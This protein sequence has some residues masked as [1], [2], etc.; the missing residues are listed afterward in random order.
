MFSNLVE[1]HV[2]LEGT[3]RPELARELARK[4]RHN[5]PENIFK[6]NSNAYQF[7]DFLDFIK[8]YD[9]VAGVI[10][11]PEDYYEVTKAYLAESAAGGVIYCEM[12]FSPSHAKMLTQTDTASTLAA[13][14]A[15]IA[16][17]E[18]DFEIVGRT[19]ITAVRHLGVEDTVSVA[20]EIESY[21]SD[22]IVGFG[23]AGDEIHYP[24]QWFTEPFDIAKQLG[25]GCTAHAGEH[26]PAS[27]VRDA[28]LHLPISR[29]GHG[30]RAIE[31]LEVCALIKDKGIA[32]EICPSSNVILQVYKNLKAHP[33]AE[34]YRAGIS[35]SINSDDPPFFATSIAEE[36]ALAK[37]IFGFDDADIRN[38]SIMAIEASFA[39][40][41]LKKRLLARVNENKLV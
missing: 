11:K 18:R 7:K 32:L 4:N 33:I 24:P 30:V 38:I 39:E 13:V 20:R 9:V 36:H 6:P 41:N 16:D 25:L 34:F 17:A 40:K 28:I 1:L 29:I 19:I 3:I 10:K 22:N 12:M 35:M 31:D 21:K 37:R 14:D 27:S 8:A 15:A 26:M 2:H 5:L 23:L